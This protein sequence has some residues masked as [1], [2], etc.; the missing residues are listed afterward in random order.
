M[1]PTIILIWLNY[2]RNYTYATQILQMHRLFALNT[3]L[4]VQPLDLFGACFPHKIDSVKFYNLG[5]IYLQCNIF[6]Q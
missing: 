6:Q 3:A 2:R 1:L 4:A 5:V